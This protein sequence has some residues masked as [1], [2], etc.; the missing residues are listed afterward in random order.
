M[1]EI[2]NN[3]E[4][5]RNKKIRLTKKVIRIVAMCNIMELLLI[6]RQS[7]IINREIGLWITNDLKAY[8]NVGKEHYCI[9][10]IHENGFLFDFHCHPGEF[11]YP[12]VE[13]RLLTVAKQSRIN[14]IIGEGYNED[15]SDIHIFG[16][17]INKQHVLY[18]HLYKMSQAYVVG[19]LNKNGTDHIREI[20]ENV[21][22]L[23]KVETNIF[24]D[25]E[26]AMEIVNGMA[27]YDFEYKI[28]NLLDKFKRLHPTK[29]EKKWFFKDLI[30]NYENGEIEVN[31]YSW[32][33]MIFC[34]EKI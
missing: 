2:R 20:I 4:C 13:D 7:E 21:T 28:N 30:D 6:F 5:L 19:A 33:D 32:K 23:F 1:F 31:D 29:D 25:A 34:R 16:Y 9:S 22:D 14:I 12:S 15:I 26:K 10:P 18:D 3:L 27:D 8:M 11:A 17:S 24:L